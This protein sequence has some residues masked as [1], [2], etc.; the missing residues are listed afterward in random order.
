VNSTNIIQELVTLGIVN[1]LCDHA[2]SADPKLR[3][4][5]LWALKHLVVNADHKLKC[6]CL[7][8]LGTGWLVQI[9]AS[10]LRENGSI[11][12]SHMATA[13]AAGEQV[14]LLNAADE[15]SM[16][17]DSE[18]EQ[19]TDEDDEMD[20]AMQPIRIAQNDVEMRRALTQRLRVIRESEENPSIKARND[21]IR[22]QEQALDF[23]RNLIGEPG[24][25]QHEMIEYL[26]LGFGATRIFELLTGKLKLRSNGS[27]QPSGTVQI[28]RGPA[29]K[30]PKLSVSSTTGVPSTSRPS[31]SNLRPS[32][33]ESSRDLWL[34]TPTD[35]VISTMFILIHIANGRPAHR[36][37]LISQTPLMT[38][39]IPCFTH[40]DR[41]VRVACCWLVHNLTWQ[42]DAADA[43]GARTRAMMLR[44]RGVEVVV[45]GLCNDDDL[46][47]RERARGVGDVFRR[48]LDGGDSA[49]TGGFAGGAVGAGMSSSESRVWSRG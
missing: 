26:L 49:M 33:T 19:L 16:D 36:H 7:E 18:L 40:P 32:S 12:K 15:P 29:G 31:I 23:I 20:D 9:L 30:Q 1:V 25:G 6:Q 48:L 24:P 45:R 17:V 14:D 28:P 47:T 38:A 41:R 35:L 4:N 27:A 42:E 21:D 34:N 39:L 46:D 13:N 37:L 8:T 5:S 22:T 3:I 11:P 43:G 44:D 2:R 10:E